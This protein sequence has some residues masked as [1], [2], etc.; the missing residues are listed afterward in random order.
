MATKWHRELDI[1]TQIKS[2]IILEGNISDIYV[3]PEGE[4]S[5]AT[6]PLTNYLY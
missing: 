3:F 1:F 6:L 2:G 5:G 4:L